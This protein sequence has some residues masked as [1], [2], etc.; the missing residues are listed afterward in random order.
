M[1]MVLVPFAVL[2]V[3]ISFIDDL[4]SLP[5]L[6]RF[7]CHA[8]AGVAVL[9]G[10][11]GAAIV[12]EMGPEL[13]SELPWLVG[14]GLGFLWVAG[15]TNAFDFMDGINGIAAGQAVVTGIGSGILVGIVT[16]NG[17]HCRCCSRSW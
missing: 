6:V 7:G 5:A 14:M 13:R 15:Y 3:G 10:L 2:I 9:F 12:F 4:K 16:G 8:A 1:L 17:F 11:G